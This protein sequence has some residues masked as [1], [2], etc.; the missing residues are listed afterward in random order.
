MIKR[1]NK[2][3]FD[4]HTHYDDESFDADRDELIRSLPAGG[5]GKIC[6]IGASFQGACDTLK[7][8]ETYD[9]VYA[10]VG[11]HPDEVEEMNEEKFAALREMAGHPKAVAIGEI[12]L[13]YHGYDI[14][15]HKPSKELQ[16]EWF[17]RQL[18]LA[19]ELDKPVV[20]HSRNAAADTMEMMQAAHDK[21]LRDAIIHCY[22]Y[23]LEQA[24]Q[25]VEMGYYI[26]FGGVITYHGQKKVTKALQGIPFDR[27]VMETD[28]PYL[29]PVPYREGTAPG[30]DFVR[31]SSLFLPAVRDKI[32]ELTGHTPEE[33]E[34]ITWENAHRVYRIPM[35]V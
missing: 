11:I 26:G 24:L 12:G 21:G 5:V 16:H 20:I 8:A 2:L 3:I 9:F 14:Y 10:A 17:E 31:N 33:V 28:C 35:T 32:A 15:E 4:T 34:R 13:D 23:S 25:Y 6:N 29:T 30:I 1:S 22:S 7:L 27:V 18:D 19:I